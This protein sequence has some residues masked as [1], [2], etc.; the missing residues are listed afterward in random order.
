MP[1]AGREMAAEGA[2]VMHP[3]TRLLLNPSQGLGSG[4]H[5][6]RFVRRN[7]A[8]MGSLVAVLEAS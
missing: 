1:A 3:A 4:E 6:R 5:G 7:V 2:H 8:N